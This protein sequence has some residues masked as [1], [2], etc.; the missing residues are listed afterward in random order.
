MVA[1]YIVFLS[2]VGLERIYE[3]HVSAKNAAAAKEQGGFEVGQRHFVAMKILHTAFLIGCGAEALFLHRPFI[4]ELGIPMFAI[5]L[6]MQ[7][8]RY[9]AV[10]SLGEAWN[11]RVIVVPDRLVTLK[12][13]YK[14]LR[15]PNYL[16]VII[17][18]IALP[19]I[20]SAWITA[21]AF[22]VLNAVI[23]FIRIRCEEQ[24]LKDHCGY[25]K[26]FGNKKRF[27]P[28]SKKEGSV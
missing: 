3:L 7:G 20:F 26:A 17:E 2:L 24:A 23:L 25:E 10:T 5:A 22:T 8:L 21:I 18:G 11:V 15:H 6:L 12:G 16:A 13:P 1:A 4:P 28:T 9:W 19:L 27:V 14:F